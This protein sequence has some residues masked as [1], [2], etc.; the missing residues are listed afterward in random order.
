MAKKRVYDIHCYL[1]EQ[2]LD[3]LNILSGYQDI[4]HSAAIRAGFKGWV[5]KL[6]KEDPYFQEAIKVYFQTKEVDPGYTGKRSKTKRGEKKMASNKLQNDFYTIRTD[7]PNG[8]RESSPRYQTVQAYGE[9]GEKVSLENL[10]ERG[11]R[12]DCLKWDLRDKYIT[13]H[14]AEGEDVSAQFADEETRVR[15]LNPKAPKA[16]KAEKAPKAKKAK[17]EAPQ[18]DEDAVQYWIQYLVEQGMSEHQATELV[19]EMGPD[20]VDE[21][22]GAAPELDQT[23]EATDEERVVIEQA[24]GV[25]AEVPQDDVSQGEVTLDDEPEFAEASLY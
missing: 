14:N 17:P 11:G 2:E 22:Y 16:P 18:W 24:L 6:H 8:K 12:K 15:V 10:I 13:L 5:Q 1:T 3:Y 20:A 25:E 4:S 21:L 7:V 19:N 9:P 23:G